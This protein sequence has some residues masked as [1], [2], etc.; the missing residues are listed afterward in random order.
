MNQTCGFCKDIET[1][2]PKEISNRYG[3]SS[4]EYR[5]GTHASFMETMKARLSDHSL[6]CPCGLDEQGNTVFEDLSPLGK[7]KVRNDDDSSIAL[8]DAWAT[9]ADVLTFYQERIANEGYLRT[10]T[11]RRSILELA[12]LVGY[13]LRPGVASSA[14]L[15][16]TLEKGYITEIPK[17]AKSKSIPDP[18]EMPQ[19]FETSD[20]L[21]AQYDLNA[22]APRMN[23]P[24]F[25]HKGNASILDTLYFKGIS[26]NLKVNDRLLMVLST[27]GR[28]EEE[29]RQVEHIDLN[30]S[31]NR[32]KVNLH[33]YLGKDNFNSALEQII[34][35]YLNTNSLCL[36]SGDEHVDKVKD[37]LLKMM[38]CKKEDDCPKAVA[39]SVIKISDYM[40]VAPWIDPIVT[41]LNKLSSEAGA[42][43]EADSAAQDAFVAKLQQ[44]V[45]PWLDTNGLSLPEGDEYVTGVKDI[46]SNLKDCKEFH[47]CSN[48]LKS[49]IEDIN[50]LQKRATP[51]K[52]V[53]SWISSLVIDLWR[54]TAEMPVD[55]AG[56][57]RMV[58]TDELVSA[59]NLFSAEKPIR[60]DNPVSPVKPVSADNPVSPDK[61]SSSRNVESVVGD[62]P[63][64]DEPNVVDMLISAALSAVIGPLKKHASIQ[65][66]S[67]SDFKRDVSQIF[68]DL[69]DMGPKMLATMNPSLGDNLY[70]ALSDVAVT[71]KSKL[72]SINVLRV[73]AAPFGHNAPLKPVIDIK[74]AV[75]G[76]EEWPLA[77]DTRLISIQ[78]TSQLVTNST[79]AKDAS[80]ST[81]P[82]K[83]SPTF[84]QA[85]ISSGHPPKA[86]KTFIALPYPQGTVSLGDLNIGVDVKTEIICQCHTKR[87]TYT[88]DF[89]DSKQ[90][91]INK[92]KIV[93]KEKDKKPAVALEIGDG[94]QVPTVTKTLTPGQTERI[95]IRD[96]KIAASYMVDGLNLISV[97]DEFGIE[98][99]DKNI[100]FLDAQYDKIKPGSWAVIERPK[101]GDTSKPPEAGEV[102]KA[103]YDRKVFRVKDARTVSKAAYGMT[104]TVTRLTL[105]DP[106]PSVKGSGEWL[107]RQDRS[108]A[109]L[110]DTTVYAQSEPLEL[111]EERI[112]PEREPVC[113][114]EIE[115]DGLYSGIEAGR[116]VIV[117]GERLDIAR[118]SGVES[119]ELAMISGVRQD[120]ARLDVVGQGDGQK[121]PLPGDKTHTFIKLAGN[122]LAYIYKRDTVTIYGNVVKATNG[123]TREEI[124]GSGDNN[125]AFQK[126]ALHQS[127]LTYIASNT[128]TGSKSTLEVKV[129]DILWHETS[130]LLENG[131]NDRVYVT[132]TDDDNKTTVVFG[133]G[134]HGARPPTDV[135]NIKAVYRVGIG[136][137]GNVKAEQI[138]QLLARPLGVKEVINP[139]RANGGADKESLSRARRN[140][141][142]A[143]MALDHLVSVADY[144][145]FASTSA[146]I[147]KA[148]AIRLS[149]GYRQVVHVTIAGEDDIPIDK[150][151]DLYRNLHENLLNFG[152]INQPIQL[153]IRELMLIIL[154]A[155]VKLLPDYF[156]DSMEPKIRQAL[157]EAFSFENR[158]LGQDVLLSEVISV[159]QKVEGVDYVDVDILDSISESTPPEEVVDIYGKKLKDPSQ[160]RQ[161]I[162][163][164]PARI[165]IDRNSSVPLI[166]PAQLAVLSS[167][168]HDTVILWE[169]KDD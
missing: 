90:A 145:D 123:E 119:S 168:I 39:N 65:P 160:P 124:L 46:L 20:I 51:C 136:S 84:L 92:I 106:N 76:Q 95:V 47:E 115:L 112:D 2:T 137:D 149:D 141:P 120:V 138:R 33:V 88:F 49:A 72:E 169:K 87:E 163:A 118:T 107:D 131:P 104:G 53:A 152:D 48:A 22:M 4:I 68:G 6:S 18:G 12:R 158:D 114:D 21:L 31:E 147:G 167:E 66:A 113:G 38:I 99:S 151:S 24:Q 146:G 98:P 25:I 82:K 36:P 28:L 159:I 94:S 42:A 121:M 111:A 78:L 74:G 93:Y 133:D 125:K 132:L 140:T 1:M 150:N 135:E 57:W 43:S 44:A 79:L 81:P 64:N 27:S 9:I 126:L 52:R 41:G 142:R 69:S 144:A 3:L 7:L 102:G 15:A 110:R 37:I 83:I 91:T 17:G 96:R 19:T 32:T 97:S 71:E 103:E 89:K 59:D 108:M 161:R 80:T 50:A 55:I 166:R 34:G 60:A 23:R 134:K 30:P 56:P 155:N 85:E 62:E 116:W 35:R 63:K 165:E 54:L 156:W 157:L 143:V 100:I 16:Y 101:P 129:N 67:S 5:V 73:K 105:E 130:S 45:N 154:K 162:K 58:G 14:Y 11:E 148:E 109:V 127:P 8:M 128:S 40:R 122:G 70:N 164:K 61:L 26:T 10:A 117:S 139:I 86:S 153:E 13:T 77:D 75:I 29:V